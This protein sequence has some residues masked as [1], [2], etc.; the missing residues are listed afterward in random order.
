[1]FARPAAG[2]RPP[3]LVAAAPSSL[4]R[5]SV[6]LRPPCSSDFGAA[7]SFAYR[8]QPCG[9]SARRISQQHAGAA[10]AGYPGADLS[11]PQQGRPS[12]LSAANGSVVKANPGSARVATLFECVETGEPA[13]RAGP[14]L[15]ERSVVG[16]TAQCL[17]GP[18]GL[19]KR[20]PSAHER[21]PE[22]ETRQGTALRLREP[23][24]RAR[25]DAALESRL[26]RL[27][28]PQGLATVRCEDGNRGGSNDLKRPSEPKRVRARPSQPQCRDANA[29]PLA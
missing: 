7:L 9:Y 24:G 4:R 5:E 29:L 19:V 15:A 23:R 20:E 1:M 13:N 26:K 8:A 22:T 28:R 6:P 18:R 10:T 12:L 16:L 21:A 17:G 14:A 3:A 11:G 2:A 25:A 27:P